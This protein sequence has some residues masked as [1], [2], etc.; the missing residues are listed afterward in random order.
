[1]P[2]SRSPWTCAI[3]EPYVTNAPSAWL[4]P[5]P[6]ASGRRSSARSDC[7]R[8]RGTAEAVRYQHRGLDRGDV[9]RLSLDRY[10]PDRPYWIT[11]REAPRIL[12][13][14]RARV[15]Q[16]R[17]SDRLPVVEHNGRHYYR[18]A[19]IEV[20]ANARASRCLQ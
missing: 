4:P 2:S 13:I 19:Q 16:L 1:M 11:E 20:L 3:R 14:S 7:R 17:R 15:F 9:E 8:P 12:G 18:R 10:K 6:R 5:L